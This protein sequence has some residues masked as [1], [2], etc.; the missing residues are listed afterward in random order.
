MNLDKVQQIRFEQLVL[1]SQPYSTKQL[2]FFQLGQCFTKRLSPFSK[3]ESKLNSITV[4]DSTV[5][6]QQMSKS[7]S[8]KGDGGYQKTSATVLPAASL[9][10][11]I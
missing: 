3:S 4:S 6:K 5:E 2:F 8:F 9:I 10:G 7:E 1:S 11:Y